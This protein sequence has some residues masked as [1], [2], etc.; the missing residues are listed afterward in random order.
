MGNKEKERIRIVHNKVLLWIIIALIIILIIL[1]VQIKRLKQDEECKIDDDCIKRQIGC[2][3]CT[4]G[5]EEIC[6]SKDNVSYLDCPEDI[7][8]PDVYNCKIKSCTC[9]NGKCVGEE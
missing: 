3:P 6:V 7:V 2:C 8:C 9:Q 5:G 1:I 4:S